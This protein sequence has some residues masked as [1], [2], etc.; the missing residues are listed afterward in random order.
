MTKRHTYGGP[1]KS[2]PDRP[3]A[4]TGSYAP[5][6]RTIPGRMRQWASY[7]RNLV[8][9]ILDEAF[10]CHL[11]F[12][13]DGLPVV[14][15]TLYARVGEHL[16]LHGSVHSGPVRLAGAGLDVCVTVTHLDGL[17]LGRSA[18]RHS[19]NYRSVVAHGVAHPV[20]DPEEKGRALRAIVEHVVPGRSSDTR[21][22]SAEELDDVA[23]LRLDLNEVSAK[24]RVGGPADEPRDAGLP[25]WSGRI[26]L[27]RSYGTPVPAEDITPGVDLPEYLSRLVGPAGPATD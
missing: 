27:L 26:P 5:T 6:E 22:P 15:P 16:Y 17:I 3:A 25:H 2:T 20:T 23:V 12:V 13:R 9:S 7:D 14:L 19:V 8:H 11:G 24:S 21:P 10:V 4:P 1:V 18:F